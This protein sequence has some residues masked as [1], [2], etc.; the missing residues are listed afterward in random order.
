MPD[1]ITFDAVITVEFIAT[2][3]PSAGFFWPPEFAEAV[4]KVP[5]SVVGD[6]YIGD[7]TRYRVILELLEES[8]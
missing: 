4:I 2:R 6:C 1:K 8:E 3:L 5:Q 7:G